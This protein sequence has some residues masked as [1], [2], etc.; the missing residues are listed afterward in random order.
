VHVEWFLLDC[1][2]DWVWFFRVKKGD[3]IFI[4]ILAINRAKDIWGEDAA[5]FRPKRWESVPEGANS[6]PGVWGNQLTFL[7]GPRACIAYRFSIV[8]LADHVLT[9]HYLV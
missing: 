2:A 8:E 9:S 5:V 6:I 1:R 7:G 4:P 3:T